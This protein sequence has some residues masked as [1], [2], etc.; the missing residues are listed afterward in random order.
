MKQLCYGCDLHEA[1]SFVRY[2]PTAKAAGYSATAPT[3]LASSSAAHRCLDTVRYPIGSM[4]LHRFHL[5][6]LVL[7]S[8]MVCEVSSALSTDR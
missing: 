4:A 3:G 2:L 6:T 7:C 8:Q 5:S 1:D